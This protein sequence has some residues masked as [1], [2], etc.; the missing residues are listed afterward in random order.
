M[1]HRI[2]QFIE[3]ER[4]YL[5]RL[6]V[7]Q[8]SLLYSFLLFT[9]AGPFIFI[10]LNA[11]IWRQSRDPQLM[12]QNNIGFYVGVMLA[13][14]LNGVLMRW[15]SI[16]KLFLAGAILQG[17]FPLFFIFI[18]GT[19]QF[20]PYIFFFGM[21]NGVG[22]GFYWA[23]RNSITSHITA[24]PNR[25]Q[26][27]S[28]ESS[29][30]TLFD[31]LLPL[32]I[33]W[34]IVLLVRWDVTSSTV[35]YQIFAVIGALILA[36][37]GFVIRNID[38]EPT[39]AKLHRTDF[40]FWKTSREW[41]HLRVVEFFNGAIE[42]V[43]GFIPLMLILLFLGEE[44]AIGTVEAVTSI[45][46]AVMLYVLGKRI[47][48]SDHLWIVA[49]WVAITSLG[50]GLFA[51]FYT[52]WALIISFLLSGLVVIFRWSSI[53]AVVYEVIDEKVASDNRRYRYILD[54]EVY[55]N[56][57]RIITLLICF[58]LYTSYGEEVL[59]FGL[60]FATL[61]QL[62]LLYSFRQLHKTLDEK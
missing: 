46:G 8:R 50:Y 51:V 19:E 27:M 20:L 37:S 38:E 47:K 16:K 35:I 31:F 55:L 24:G 21:L 26:F 11:F 57:G 61:L 10:Y 49:A 56:S 44:N 42:G 17:V 2:S 33:G 5:A 58:V 43:T 22:G 3:R 32:V 23:N 6:T 28:L 36:W 7:D 4:A 34:S 9:L 52:P 62:F 41:N 18:G 1:F 13:F 30:G 15:F 48:R 29:L 45:L 54:R 25:F 39:T 59:R 14:Y 60:L 40:F 12:L 53:M